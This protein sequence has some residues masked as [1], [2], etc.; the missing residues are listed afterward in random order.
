L[1]LDNSI[2]IYI[3]LISLSFTLLGAWIAFQLMPSKTKIVHVEKEKTKPDDIVFS[4]N[5]ARLN[6]L[7]LSPR[8]HQILSLLLKG[9]SNAEIAEEL[10]LSLSTT[11]THVSNLYSKMHVKSRFQVIALAKKMNILY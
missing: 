3:G 11:K 9:Y 2:D 5:Q 1:I 10:F 4:I 6:Q 7:K 8:E